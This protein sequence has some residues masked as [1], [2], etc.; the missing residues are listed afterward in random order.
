MV[1]GYSTGLALGLIVAL[2]SGLV[3][4]LVGGLALSGAWGEKIHVGPFALRDRPTRRDARTER[5]GVVSKVSAVRSSH[6]RSARQNRYYAQAIRSRDA[7]IGV[8]Q[9]SRAERRRLYDP[10]VAR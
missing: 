6:L 4:I 5:R 9:V 8:D 10:N 1:I 3:I 2:L 7:V